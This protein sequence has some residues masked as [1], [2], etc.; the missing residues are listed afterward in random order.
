MRQIRD[1]RIKNIAA[2]LVACS[3]GTIAG[4]S[5][6][7]VNATPLAAVEAQHDEMVPNEPMTEP[8]RKHPLDRS[9]HKQVGEASFYASRYAGR[10]MA[11]GTPMRLG[12]NN[13]ASLTLPLGTTARVV[14]LE[15]GRSAVVTIRDR[16]P[17]VKGRIVDL[18][19]AT[20]QKIGLD[21]RRGVARVEVVPLSV[22]LP[23]GSVWTSQPTLASN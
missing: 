8:G 2:L 16:G 13:A 17:Y 9:G 10:T 5:A 20:A 23:D 7:V 19:P 22:P 11:D 14:N 18:S 3:V 6:M 12:G 15:T 21:R 4:T 1:T